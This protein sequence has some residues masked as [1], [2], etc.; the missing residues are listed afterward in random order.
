M[1][2]WAHLGVEGF[3]LGEEPWLNYH[4]KIAPMIGKIV[5]ALTEEAVTMNHLTV[6]LHLLMISFYHPTPKR[7]KIICE[8]K[9]FPSDQYALQSQVRFHGFNPD[10]AIIEVHPKE[11]TELIT[12]ED[13]L[14]T[15]RQHKESVALVLFAGKQ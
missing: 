9:A 2:A 12:T 13:I 14:V 11:G 5:G 8:A 15:I 4:K 6:N 10:D 1:T 3:F 7:Y